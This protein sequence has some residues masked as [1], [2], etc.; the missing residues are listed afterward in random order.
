MKIL[1][2]ILV[3]VSC[4]LLGFYKHH[5]MTREAEA[6]QGVTDA[7][8]YIKKQ[9]ALSKKLISELIESAVE[10]A[11][12]ASPLFLS[13]LDALKAGSITFSD[14]WADAVNKSGIRDKRTKQ[15]LSELGMQLGKNDIEGELETVSAACEKLSALY[16]TMQTGI[17]K[18]GALY[19]KAGVLLGVVIVILLY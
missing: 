10:F 16:E 12:E 17:C 8:S 9:L 11:G 5:L 3:V 1:G 18:E 7:L 19:K 13:C 6:V 4:T 14:A 15:I 2:S